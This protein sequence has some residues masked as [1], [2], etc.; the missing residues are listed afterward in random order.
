MHV[1]HLIVALDCLRI[2]QILMA[3]WAVAGNPPDSMCV[4]QLRPVLCEKWGFL[5]WD[6]GGEGHCHGKLGP[7]G[8]KSA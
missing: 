7:Q 2:H 1:T 3:S 8:I 5:K 6:P 4:Y